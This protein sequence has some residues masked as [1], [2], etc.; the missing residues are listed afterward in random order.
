[1]IVKDKKRGVKRS[2]KN[3]KPSNEKKT[4]L[5]RSHQNLLLYGNVAI[6]NYETYVLYIGVGI[7]HS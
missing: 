2:N 1:M 3:L 5:C 6:I 4:L 7:V